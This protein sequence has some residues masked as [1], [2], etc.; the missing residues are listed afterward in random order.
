V[1]PRLA[2][3]N[4][5]SINNFSP[6][7]ATYVVRGLTL[8]KGT[9][10]A[11][12]GSTNRLF[13]TIAGN[14]ILDSDTGPFGAIDVT[15]LAGGSK[16]AIDFTIRGNT[17]TARPNPGSGSVGIRIEPGHEAA[18]SGAITGNRV[19]FPES[20][21]NGS[22]IIVRNQNRSLSVDVIGNTTL[23]SHYEAGIFLAQIETGG[24]LAARVANNVIQG[25]DDE[26]ELLGIDGD[27]GQGTLRVAIVNNTFVR[28]SGGINLENNDIQGVLDA[29]I[30]NNVIAANDGIGVNVPARLLPATRFG[31]NLLFGVTSSH[32]TPGTL[33]VDPRFAGPDDFRLAADSPAI[34]AGAA[35]F[36]P[37]DLTT[38]FA[39]NP[40]IVDGAVDLGAFE[41]PCADGSFTP[42][43]C[44]SAP[45]PTDACIPA[46]C[47][48]GDPC[49]VD[50][51]AAGACVHVARD[52]IDGARC[53]CERP[54]P[55]ACAADGFPPA[56]KR[57]TS[58]ACSL[59][60]RAAESS[61]P[62]RILRRAAHTW[63]GA[64]KLA[65]R[66]RVTG[67]R[68]PQCRSDLVAA[69]HDAERRTGDA[70]TTPR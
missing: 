26:S 6:T 7:A 57:R 1:H 32:L 41:A 30:A 43:A 23:G 44:P 31:P 10:R 21:S 51:C 62:N 15:T 65:T 61:R 9:I 50:D 22:P 64:A 34:D 38:D 29:V 67:S 54:A 4:D 46:Q 39:G 3:G 52:G 17:V 13:V 45:P 47:D 37:D 18:A 16:G 68:T 2:P 12:Q 5:V 66:R 63:A 70:V 35:A 60:T 25:V 49:T 36:L 27:L 42:E 14:V 58:R 69:L 20:E 40:R 53:A 55:A 8:E 24:T 33:F 11:T 28:V 19:N 48:D 56:V 59:L